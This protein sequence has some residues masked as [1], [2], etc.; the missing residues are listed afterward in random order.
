MSYQQKVE[1]RAKLL[2]VTYNFLNRALIWASEGDIPHDDFIQRYYRTSVDWRLDV[3]LKKADSDDP[4]TRE[5]AKHELTFLNEDQVKSLV[6]DILEHDAGGKIWEGK[7]R[8]VH[9][10]TWDIVKEQLTTLR[11]YYQYEKGLKEMDCLKIIKH[12]CSDLIYEAKAFMNLV[13][14]QNRNL[15]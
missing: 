4:S 1:E 11:K 7:L 14:A 9:Y 13:E 6:I 15:N 10:Y 3:I 8:W 5:H 12:L 2:N